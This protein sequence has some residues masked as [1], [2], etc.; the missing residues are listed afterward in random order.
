MMKLLFSSIAAVGLI[1][2]P[3]MA[4]DLGK[5]Y[6]KAPPPA[7]APPQIF[8]WTGCYLGVRAGGGWGRTEF[9]DP[10]VQL[11]APVGGSL[12]DD[13]KG[14]VV[15][16]SLGCDYQFAT[17]FVIGAEVAGYWANIG[18]DQNVGFTTGS[19]GVTVSGTAHSQTDWLASIAGRLGFAWDR[20]L[21]YGKGG[22]AFAGDKYSMVGQTVCLGL[23]IGGN[24]PQ[25]LNV[26]GSET[27]LGWVAGVGLEYA[28][29]D[30][31]SATLEYDWYQF[32]TDKVFFSGTP[33]GLEPFLGAPANIS[34]R[35]QTLV[36]GVTY[37]F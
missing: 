37:R 16:G 3:A 21:V 19:P 31:W 25:P 28:F 15:G 10:D 12:N 9:F 32:G 2:A 17:S 23:C 13:T 26:N 6:Y 4:A 14:A 18:G 36:G 34:Q 20:L 27:R 11:F 24:A 33:V 7:L 29:W 30:H 35:I 5:P 1:G 22:V 8:S